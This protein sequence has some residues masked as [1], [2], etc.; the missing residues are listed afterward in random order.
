MATTEGSTIQA[1]FKVAIGN[2]E[3]AKA[4]IGA[5]T[6]TRFGEVEVNWPMI[7]FYCALTEDANP[8]YWDR[9]F[10][11]RTWGGIISPPGMLMTWTMTHM[12]HPWGDGK[13]EEEEEGPIAAS[14]PL[15]G[16]TLINVSTETELLRPVHLGE[17]LNTV[18]EI[19]DVSPEKHTRLGTG[20]FITMVSTIRD[21]RGDVVARNTN[22]LLRFDTGRQ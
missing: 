10:A 1:G 8:S 2:Y 19:A 13:E 11:E 6:D 3:E 14:V 12:W 9:D 18:D 4:W 5:R 20:H 17:Y 22:I 21:Q 16:D 7:T 15:P